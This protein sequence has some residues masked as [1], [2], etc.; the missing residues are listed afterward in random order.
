VTPLEQ[1]RLLTTVSIKGV[2]QSAGDSGTTPFS[3]TVSLDSSSTLPI[4]VDYSTSDGTA[5]VTDNNYQPQAGTLTFSPGQTSETITILVN[6]DS[7][8]HGN[9]TFFVNL[10]NPVN[11]QLTA[12]GQQAVGIILNNEGGTSYYVN[13]DSTVGD[14]FCTAPGSYSN[15]GLTPATPIASLYTLL[16]LYTFHPGDTIYVDT[17]AYAQVNNVVLG[18][19]DSGVNIVGPGTRQVT[20][21]LTGAAVLADGPVAFW[22]LGDAG[23]TTAADS[24][25]NGYSGTY[26]GDATPDP[27]SPTN[28]GAALFNGQESYVTVPYA[29]ALEP[30][31]FTIEAWVDFQDNSSAAFE[32]IINIAGYRLYENNAGELAFATLANYN[33]A[34]APLEPGVWNF[35]VATLDS[36]G[37][38]TASLY[39]N[40][41]LMDSS[42]GLG[43]VTQDGQPLEIGASFSTRQTTT[44]QGGICEVALYNKILT[45]VQIQAQFAA[46]VYSGAVLDRG[47]TSSGSVGIELAGATDVTISNLSIADATAGIYAG[48]DA[49]SAGLMVIDADFYGNIQGIDLESSN[50]GADI[51]DSTFR[52]QSKDGVYIAANS[53]TVSGNTIYGSGSN[54]NGAGGVEIEGVSPTVS[55]NIIYDNLGD[56]ILGGVD[57]NEYLI[58]GNE[59]YA[60]GVGTN[61]AGIL[62]NTLNAVITGNQVH[63]NLGDGTSVGSDGDGAVLAADNTIYGN[64]QTGVFLTGDAEARDNVVY[65]NQD[66]ITQWPGLGGV[67]GGATIDG[68]AGTIDG[69]RVFANTGVGITAT[70]DGAVIDNDVYSNATGIQGTDLSFPNPNAPVAGLSFPFQG[71]V[72]NNIV[73][74]NSSV[75]ILIADGDG[76]QG[77]RAL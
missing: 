15:N 75:G 38:N 29:P 69:N 51:F 26:V 11:A 61:Y 6:A 28:D 5:S 55:N 3:F 25:G 2:T 7:P 50:D 65:D 27:D 58:S 67:A 59:V 53:P 33:P 21:S 41:V 42:Q 34:T 70:G 57:G 35:V 31:Q 77:Q 4:S 23:G 18:P 10:A 72:S 8:P 1:R 63:D 37:S 49:E 47:N 32:S 56:G 66:G 19:Q 46:E 24:S 39:V 54:I 16:S 48:P 45:P 12:T 30:S 73:Y 36:A 17:G 60:N 43:Q 13:D 20:P 44:W 68:S 74:A 9:E 52:G 71:S 62:V 64:S 76:A 22:R 40:G 14:V